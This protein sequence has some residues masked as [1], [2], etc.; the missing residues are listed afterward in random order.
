MAI[1][2]DAIRSNADLHRALY[3]IVGTLAAAHISH[4][5]AAIGREMLYGLCKLS[6]AV[7][8]HLPAPPQT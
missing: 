7:L 6:A 8:P 5:E 2:G 3:R 1:L 4:R